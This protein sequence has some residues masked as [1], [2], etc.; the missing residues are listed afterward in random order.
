M[1]DWIL[2]ELGEGYITTIRTGYRKD[3]HYKR[4]AYVEYLGKTSLSWYYVGKCFFHKKTYFY[5][6]FIS[7][8]IFIFLFFIFRLR[9]K[10]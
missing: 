5:K 6:V 9:V 3:K 7:F 1:E 8:L 2:K 4:Q 10:D